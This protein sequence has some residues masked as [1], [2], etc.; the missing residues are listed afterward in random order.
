MLVDVVGWFGSAT[1]PTPGAKITAQSPVRV[2]DTRQPGFTKVGQGESIEV[3]VAAAGSGVNGVVLNVT[4]T[5]PTTT[6]FVTV[7]PADQASPPN[8]SNLNVVAGDTRP[9]MVIVKVPTTGPSA[10]K[11]KLY[12]AFGSTHLIVDVMA[13]FKATTAFDNQ[14]VGRLLPLTSPVRLI[15]TR[16]EGGP[17]GAGQV[18]SWDLRAVDDATPANI[19]GIVAN[20]TATQATAPTFLTLYP[21]GTSTPNASNLNVVPGADVPNSVVVGLSASDALSVFNAAGSVQY[22]VDVSALVIGA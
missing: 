20:A 5:Q 2:L 22:I 13:T 3:P 17:L 21:S 11:I 15:D 12:N 6:S 9:N 16:R 10:G 1:A 14:P 19:S 18:A 7:Y 4:A 8:A